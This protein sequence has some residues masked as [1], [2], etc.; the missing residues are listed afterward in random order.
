MTPKF[1]KMDLKEKH[2]LKTKLETWYFETEDWINDCDFYK[3][4]LQFLK[5]IVQNKIQNTTTEGQEHKEIYRHIEKMLVR[6]FDEI[7]TALKDHKKHLADAMTRKGIPDNE[8]YH[9]EMGQKMAALKNG[10]T[11]LKR[12]IFKYVVETPVDTHDEAF[13]EM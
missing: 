10:I 4:E 8:A 13:E 7:T 11:D 12:S 6:L 3:E 9:A 2:L 1:H 5:E